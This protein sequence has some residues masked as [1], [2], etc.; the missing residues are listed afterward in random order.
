MSSSPESSRRDILSNAASVAALGLTALVV[1]PNDA[2]ALNLRTDPP[3]AQSVANKAAESYQGVYTD[4]MHPEGYRVIMAS[5]KGATMTISDGVAKDAPE[6]TEAKTYKNVPVG[7][8]GNELS[9][10]FGFS[11]CI[12]LISSCLYMYASVLPLIITFP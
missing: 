7:V 4:P 9:F 6:G 11:K 8:K 2:S 3:T 10:D 5:G 12:S 1:D